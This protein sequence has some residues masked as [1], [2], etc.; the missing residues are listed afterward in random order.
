MA[1]TR[2]MWVLERGG[3]I[4]SEQSGFR[5]N[6]NTTDHLVQFENDVKDSITTK[7]HTIAI[8]FDI[9]KAYD[10]AWRPWSTANFM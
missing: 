7:Q 10:T 3:H 6:R 8:F 2:L 5:K 4:P 9:K 1:N